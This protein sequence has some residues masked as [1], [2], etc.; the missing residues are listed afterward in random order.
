VL[1]PALS[2]I[3]DASEGAISDLPE[4]N[5]M[6]SETITFPNDSI[7]CRRGDYI[8]RSGVGGLVRVYR[9]DDLIKLSRLLPWGDAA[10]IEEG[11]LLDSERPAF[12]DEI[13][14]LLSVFDRSFASF[15][16]GAHAIEA[17]DLGSATGGHCLD[18]RDFPTSSSQV[19][20]SGAGP[21]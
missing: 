5:P 11:A 20:R 16:E 2:E 8:L 7:R 21:G 6:P 17:G 19:H 9:V 14:L 1:L 4:A 15:E 18:I 12:M 10:V 3:Q 13:H